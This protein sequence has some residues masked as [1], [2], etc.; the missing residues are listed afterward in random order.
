MAGHLRDA[1]HRSFPEIADQLVVSTNTVKTQARSIYGKLD[2]SS[3]S[4][5]VERARVAGLLDR[6]GSS[7]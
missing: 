7:A 5:A 4:E 2:V 3:R 6:D 1:T